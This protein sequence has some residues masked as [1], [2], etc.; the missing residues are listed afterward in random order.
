MAPLAVDAL[1]EDEHLVEVDSMLESR[2]HV[3]QLPVRREQHKGSAADAARHRRDYLLD[4]AIEVL[5]LRPRQVGGQ[6]HQRLVEEVERRGQDQLLCVW[7]K[8]HPRAEVVEG[9]PD[10]QRRGGEDRR[11]P[12][13]VDAVAQQGADVDRRCAKHQVVGA[14]EQGEPVDTVRIRGQKRLAQELGSAVKPAP[15]DLELPDALVGLDAA[16]PITGSTHRPPK[17]GVKGR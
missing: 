11:S 12:L 1:A 6:A 13:G 15:N 10:G 17:H 5:V 14:R 16:K 4:V 8:S 9:A 7:A 2:M 3:A